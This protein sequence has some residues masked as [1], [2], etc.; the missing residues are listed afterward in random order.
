LWRDEMDWEHFR[1]VWRANGRNMAQGPFEA[2]VQCRANAIRR[3]TVDVVGAA[4]D[5]AD[6]DDDRPAAQVDGVGCDVVSTGCFYDFLERREGRFGL[7]SVS[8]SISATGSIR[9]ITAVRRHWTARL[10]DVL[11][12]RRR[13]RV[14][15]RCGPCVPDAIWT[16][17]IHRKGRSL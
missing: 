10:L 14:R 1:T 16:I 8:R 15:R 2:F 9:W 6:E 11:R 4:R 12:P 7:I 17:R 3:R 13:S 5:R